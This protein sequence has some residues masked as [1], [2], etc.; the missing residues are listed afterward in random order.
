MSERL[1]SFVALSALLTGFSEVQLWGSGIAGEH[2][3]VLDAVLPADIVSDLIDAF[4]RLPADDARETAIA[5]TILADPRLGPIARNL[6]V[7]WYSGIWTQLPA[8]WR[9]AYGASPLD[10]TRT[11]SGAAYRAGL[12]WAVA[13]AHP[14][15]AKHQG[16]GSWALEPKRRRA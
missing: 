2:L 15:G 1:E 5:T 11:T 12:Q 10:V 13:G 3:A 7:L 16:F 6:I 4:E 14:P 9:E 8:A